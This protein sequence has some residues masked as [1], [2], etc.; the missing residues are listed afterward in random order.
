MEE[1]DETE[2]ESQVY[3]ACIQHGRRVGVSYYDCSVRQLHVLEVWEEDCSDF[4]LINMVK[5]QA[6]PLVIYTSTK[7]DDSFVSALQQSDG[8]DEATTV[9]LVKSSTFSYEQ[10]WHRLVYLRVTGM[11]EGLNIKER[12]CYLS[13]MMDVGSEVQ[14]RVS[15]GLLAILESE[16]IVDTLEQNE[17]GTASIAIDSV[18]EVPLNK[19]LK[20]DAA[21]H[22]ALQIFQ[23]DKHPSHMGIGRAKEGFSV[24]GVMNKCATP[25]GRRLL[26][27]WFMRPI[28]DLEVLDRRLNAISFFI[29]SVELMTSLRETLKSVKDIS[30]LL[31]KFN[32]PTSL[33]TNNDWTAFMKSIGALLHVNKILEVG[34]S[35]SLREHMRRFN[36]DI[37]EKAGLC[38]STELDYVYELVL[39]VIDVTRSKEKGYQTLVKDGFCAEVI[40]EIAFVQ[41]VISL[42][43]SA[44]NSFLV[45]QLDELRQIYEELPDFLQEVSSMELEHLP[46]LHKEKLPPSIVYIQQIGYL[47]CIFGE[48]LDETALDRLAEFE[49]AF[50]DLDGET[51]R[52]FYHT[53]KTRELD[54]LLGDIYHKI[55]DMERA[56]VRDLLSHTLLFS[57]HLLRAVNFVAEL[58]CILSLACVA[59][60]NNYVRPVLTT[61]SLLDIRNGRHVLQEMAVDTFIPND[62]EINDNGRIHIITGPNYS[63]KSIF[64]KQV[65]LIVFL[66]HIGSFVPADAATV[67]LT[68]RIFCA[69]GSKFMTAEQSTFMID[70][71]QVG[72][73]LRQATSRSLCLLDEF[74]K[75]TLTEDGIGLLGGT[76]SHFASCNEPPRVLVCTHLT[77]LLNESCLPV[78]EKIRFYTMSVLRPDTESANM[79]EI[80]F[81]YRY[82]LSTSKL[83]RLHYQNF[84]SLCV[85]EEV[86]KRA[87]SVLDAF[88]S[89]NNVNKLNL[90]NIS[91]QDQAFK[92]A[93]DRFMEFDISKGDICAFFQDM[94]TS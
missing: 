19:F 1:A 89:N 44:S 67:G 70:L 75:G 22:E 47:M 60:Q 32:S 11:D 84:A 34:V 62:T 4:T 33:C 53:P 78:S 56:I 29:S 14:V 25:M 13:S 65:A 86:V 20:L 40:I 17:S 61:E 43:F 38:I 91:S 93:V 77:E 80:V 88:E 50:S 76:I 6:K 3:M 45:Y 49:F 24:F 87:S 42:I 31:K 36:L 79:E 9:K 23:T 85:P 58:D 10:A 52:F 71:H 64:V 72:M 39:G 48:K 66:S 12:V 94:F 26:R 37:V 54:N 92:D 35:E 81:L 8:T 5:Y 46:H 82:E 59:H 18:M 83:N 41:V 55:L 68:D 15:G 74:G 2:T 73:M 57:A 7:S 27:S 30:H 90:D 28:L 21:A 69:M 16:R 51:Q 63:G